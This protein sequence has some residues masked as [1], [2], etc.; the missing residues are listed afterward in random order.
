MA[1]FKPIETVY[2][3]YRFRSRLEA[4]WA[5]FFDAMGIE[6]QYEPEGFN[7]G[8]RY[9]LPD[10]YLPWWHCYVEIKPDKK[11]AFDVGARCCIDLFNAMPGIITMLCAGDPMTDKM[12][13]FC[14]DLTDGSGGGPNA[15]QIAFLEGA[16]WEHGGYTKHWIGIVAD[17]S[18]GDRTFYTSDWV[19][20]DID[21]AH[22]IKSYRSRFDNAKII[23]RQ[24]RFEHGETPKPP[25]KTSL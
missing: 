7:I 13:V 6:Y 2:N 25:K 17:G 23:A 8:G 20:A 9:Y 22:G 3:G 11:T 1:D 10:F 15:W 5:V 16:Q 12:Y 19:A 21:N 18:R 14:N 24:A 4:R